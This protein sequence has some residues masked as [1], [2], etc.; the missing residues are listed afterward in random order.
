[1]VMFEVKIYLWVSYV[2]VFLAIAGLAGWMLCRG[3]KRRAVLV[4]VAVGLLVL[5]LVPYGLVEGRTRIYA[6]SLRPAVRQFMRDT[7]WEEPI[8]I[9][10]LK[11]LG[12]SPRRATVYVVAPCPERDME[13]GVDSDPC[14]C[15]YTVRLRKS[16]N[17]WEFIA[18]SDQLIWSDCGRRADGNIFP[19]YPS[20]NAYR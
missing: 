18:W 19:P 16:R 1:M 15:A 12:I 20:N 5:P 17:Q 8:R 7:R 2:L 10:D 13:P 6:D 14:Y 3:G 4:M 9:R 11:V